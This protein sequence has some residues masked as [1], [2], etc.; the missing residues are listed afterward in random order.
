MAK[1]S[2]EIN[3]IQLKELYYENFI[4]QCNLKKVIFCNLDLT[5]TLTVIIILRSEQRTNLKTKTKNDR[6]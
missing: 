1:N 6:K 2:L 4:K 5:L 3:P